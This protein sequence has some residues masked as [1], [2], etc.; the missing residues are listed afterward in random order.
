MQCSNC[1]HE[2]RPDTRFCTKCGALAPGAPATAPVPPAQPTSTFGAQPRPA[3]QASQMGG[4][5]RKSGCGKVLLVLALIGVVALAGVG[6]AVYYGYKYANE[7]QKSS[8][9]YRI[10]IEALKQNPEATQRLGEIKETGFPLGSFHEDANG[11][12]AAAYKVSIVGT[13]TNGDYVVV[14]TRQ[15]AQW[16]LV[17]AKLTLPNGDVINIKTPGMNL[18]DVNLP[19]TDNDNIEP[20]PPP[21]PTGK[22]KPGTTISGGFLNSKA[23][24][25]PDPQYPPLAKAARASGTVTV[26]VTIDETGKVISANAVAGHPLLQAAAVQAAYQARFTPI[27]LGGQPVKVTGIIT[28][29]FVAQ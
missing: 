17:T 19:S 4:P 22:I 24:S 25:K 6:I 18:P 28:Y 26:Q 13:K 2:L 8:E 16:S 14:L 3:Y 21:P 10:A 5:P 11:T 9:P 20:P 27:Q 7:R 23:I 15:H 1:G 29:N 12:G